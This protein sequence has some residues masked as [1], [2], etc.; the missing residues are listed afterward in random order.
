MI[1]YQ[2]TMRPVQ[3]TMETT[4][5]IVKQGSVKKEILHRVPKNRYHVVN[6]VG[7]VL[8]RWRLGEREYNVT[9]KVSQHGVRAA[10]L[11]HAVFAAIK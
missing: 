4:Y 5:L 7:R 1:I 6:I 11:T 10:V 3:K 9:G 8:M 2:V